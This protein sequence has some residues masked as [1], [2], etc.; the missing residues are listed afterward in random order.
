MSNSEEKTRIRQ[1]DD[2]SDYTL[3][4]IR[5]KAA[6]SAKKLENVLK[7]NDTDTEKNE[8]A[9]NIIV[10]LLSDKAL[11]VMRSVIGDPSS[12]LKHSKNIM[13]LNQPGQ[14]FLKCLNSYQ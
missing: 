6:I 5:I 14:N 3:C 13:I 8:E 10:S 1:L 9:R 12:M 11:R 7:G 4:R 2:K